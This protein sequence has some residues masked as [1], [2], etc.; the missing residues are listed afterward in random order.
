MDWHCR[1][2]RHGYNGCMGTESRRYLCICAAN[3]QRSPTAE[4]VLWRMAGER[5]V[6]LEVRSAGISVLCENPVTEAMVREADVIFVMED[7]M[8][9]ELEKRHV[10]DPGK[11]VCLDIPDVY[12]R[13]EPALVRILR[14]VFDPYVHA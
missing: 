14:E 7:Y 11:I 4:D 13:D 1:K 12:D 9:R 2:E 10:L 6:D 3:R 8:A 5:G